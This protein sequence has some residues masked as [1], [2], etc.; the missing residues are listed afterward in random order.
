V[1]IESLGGVLA[2]QLRS[3]RHRLQ[4][5]AAA[6]THVS[7]LPGAPLGRPVACAF[8]VHATFHEIRFA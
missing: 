2:R 5:F 3:R 7:S 6:E 1:G 4:A 8:R